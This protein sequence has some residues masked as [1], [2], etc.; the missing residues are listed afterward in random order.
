MRDQNVVQN[1]NE[2]PHEKDGRNYGHG[3]PVLL[4]CSRRDRQGLVRGVHHGKIPRADIREMVSRVV[5]QASKY[6]EN[7][8]DPA[9]LV[10]GVSQTDLHE[11][12][13]QYWGYEEFRPKQEAVIRSLLAGRDCAVIMP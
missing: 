7:P 5:T 3:G 11:I 1:G 6:C 2:A 10:L 12:L 4:S 8:A 13:R 9:L